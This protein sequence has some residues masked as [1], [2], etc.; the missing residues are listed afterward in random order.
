MHLYTCNMFRSI[1]ISKTNKKPD[2][3]ISVCGTNLASK[4]KLFPRKNK[5]VVRFAASE[6]SEGS[7]QGSQEICKIDTSSERHFKAKGRVVILWTEWMRQS[8]S[9]LSWQHCTGE[10]QLQSEQMFQEM[11]CVSAKKCL[12]WDCRC[13]TTG[14]KLA[15]ICLWSERQNGKGGKKD[16]NMTSRW[17]W[18]VHQPSKQT[19]FR[20]SVSFSDRAS[21]KPNH[22]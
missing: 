20:G 5:V 22:G 12:V 7:P 14:E 19:C 2:I 4:Q 3:L 9:R 6:Q 16:T 21:G 11:G 17:G 1:K 15:H 18:K 10:K 13:H 8:N